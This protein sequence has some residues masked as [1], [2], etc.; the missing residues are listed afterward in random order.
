MMYTQYYTVQVITGIRRVVDVVFETENYTNVSAFT[1]KSQYYLHTPFRIDWSDAAEQHT[2]IQKT[3]SSNRRRR[4]FVYG[5]VV[6]AA[7]HIIEDY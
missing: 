1:E 7:V 5:S 4:L 6:T 3:H 2:Q